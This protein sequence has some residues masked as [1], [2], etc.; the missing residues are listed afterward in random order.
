MRPS[1]GGAR[2]AHAMRPSRSSSSKKCREGGFLPYARDEKLARPWVKPG[3]PGLLHRIGGIEKQVGTGN[4]DYS[5]GNHQAMT[6]MPPR[7][8]RR[9]RRSYPEQEVDARRSRAASSP[10]IGWGSTYGP[11]HQAR[12]RAP[13]MRGPRRQPHPCPPPLAVA[14]RI[15]AHLLKSYE[16]ILVPEMNTG[17]FKTVLRDQYLVDAKP[18]T[19][20]PASPSASARS[21]PRLTEAA[22]MRRR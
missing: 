19:R 3:T 18:S 5:P 8:G 6:D 9:H 7:Q 4:I 21:R 17:Q 1:R 10:S 12:P 22:R 11:I 14:E 20:S 13:R 2:H 16:K 15:W